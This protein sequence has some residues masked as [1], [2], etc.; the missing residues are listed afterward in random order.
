[1]LKK[2]VSSIGNWLTSNTHFNS[3]NS[4]IVHMF[5][6]IIWCLSSI[7]QNTQKHFN[8]L[9]TLNWLLVTAKK[10]Q[11]PKEQPKQQLIFLNF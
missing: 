7:G 10:L 3:I 5:L 9:T 11:L 1:M 6:M 4:V 8:M 2:G